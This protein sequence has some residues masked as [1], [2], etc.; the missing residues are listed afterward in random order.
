MFRSSFSTTTSQILSILSF[1]ATLKCQTLFEKILF[2]SCE[3]SVAHETLHQFYV[4]AMCR[5]R[6]Y[7]TQQKP[8]KFFF[9]DLLS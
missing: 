6:L 5:S 7:S 2:F 1:G 9:E 4:E 3:S 8:E